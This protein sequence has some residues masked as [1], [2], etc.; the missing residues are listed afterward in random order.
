MAASPDAIVTCKCCGQ[1]LLEIKCPLQIAYTTPQACLP[2]YLGRN[3]GNSLSL[4]VSSIPHIGLTAICSDEINV[5][6]FLCFH[7]YWLSPTKDSQRLFPEFIEAIHNASRLIFTMFV[8]PRLF[9]ISD[10]GH[11]TAT[12]IQHSSQIEAASSLTDVSIVN[13]QT[14]ITQIMDPSKI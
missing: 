13:E 8:R 7:T 2:A 9:Q 14:P 4:R 1:G 10:S 3:S 12:T 5:V 11:V 6:R